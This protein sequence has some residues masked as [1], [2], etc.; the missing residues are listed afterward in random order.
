VIAVDGGHPLS[1]SIEASGA[2]NAALPAVVATLLT[3]H[4]VDIGGIPELSD[5][6][7][8]IALV[9][10]LGKHATLSGTVLTVTEGP[11]LE[12]VAPREIVRR[13]R[14]SFLVL[15]PLVARLGQ[16]Q[17][18]LPGGCSIGARPVDLHLKGLAALGAEV[19]IRDGVVF[20]RAQRLRGA[21]VQLDFPSVGATE[22]LLLAGALAD[23]E[24]VIVNPA[25]EPEVQ[26]LGRLLTTMGAP[27][28]WD[29]DSVQVQ[30][31]SE[32]SGG[33]HRVIADRI[34]TGTYLLAGAITR[35]KVRVTQ[36]DP[37]LQSALLSALRKAGAH[38]DE[39]DNWLEVSAPHK[40]RAVDIE[41]GPY[42]GFPTDLQPPWVSLMTTADGRSSTTETVF[43]SRFHHVPELER[44]GARIRMEGR[45][46][47]AEGPVCLR[48][49]PVAATDIRAGAALLTAALAAEGRTELTGEELLRRGYD[50][51]VNK[52]QGLGAH[53]WESKARAAD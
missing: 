5:L 43:E 40:L 19:D 36:T 35:G 50:K 37:R 1:G 17:V 15:G 30:G 6:E 13:M 32:L 47:I 25:R 2:K 20:A 42:P 16:A 33:S 45:D 34:E 10:S 24:T 31:R 23:G 52:L 44:M 4:P 12:P 7:T 14:A 39:G 41:T 27:V 28:S 38:V 8:A 48:G 3:D 22:Q 9:R 49:A 26:D 21:T 51:Y 29:A 11:K 46:I 53:I 18:P